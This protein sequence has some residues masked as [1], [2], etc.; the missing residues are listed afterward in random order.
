MNCYLMSRRM[1]KEKILQSESELKNFQN[2]AAICCY[3][4]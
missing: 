4:K 2:N 1:G 3:Y